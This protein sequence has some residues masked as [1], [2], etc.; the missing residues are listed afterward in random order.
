MNDKVG[1]IILGLAILTN[2]LISC[3]SIQSQKVFS[4]PPISQSADSTI[5][6]SQALASLERSIHQQVDRYRQSQNLPSLTLNNAI[7]NQARKHS[8]A[9]AQGRVPFSH[10][11]FKQR[12]QIIGN[13]ISYR[14][15]AENVA[16]NQGYRDPATVAVEGWLKSPDHLK[17]IRG[18]F[19]LTGI[20][21]AQNSKGEYYFTQIFVQRR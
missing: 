9:M 14:S 15:A 19:D 2:G 17:N 1:K 21:V 12:V 13:A 11:G 3:Q 7:S 16:V 4:S 8:E 10:D 5:A 6:R 18:Q 20:G